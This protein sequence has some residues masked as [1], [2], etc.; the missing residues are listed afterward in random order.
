MPVSLSDMTTCPT[1][2]PYKGHGCYAMGG[3]LSIHWRRLSRG[4]YAF[5]QGRNYS[6]LPNAHASGSYDEF[7]EQISQ[8][9][10]GTIWRHNQAGDLAGKGDVIDR[11]M[12]E[13]LVKANVGR[14]GFTYT[15]KPVI[16]TG[17]IPGR[18]IRENRAI[19]EWMNREGFTVN[20]SCNNLRH[21]DIHVQSNV[22]AP[23][24]VVLHSDTDVFQKFIK[25]RNGERVV[26]CPNF[27]D[28]GKTCLLC[29]LCQVRGKRAAVGFPAHG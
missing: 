22:E 8:L 26:I 18:V 24:V 4:D 15:D 20:V 6:A 29:G 2:C 28:P 9:S 21:L 3:P 19:V 25:T 17:S 1:T 12:A 5:R 7:V 23:L 27:R 10:D 14:R 16:G 11:G 13:K